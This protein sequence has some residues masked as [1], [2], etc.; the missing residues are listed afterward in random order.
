[1]G[2]EQRDS[3][4][5]RTFRHES[6]RAVATLIRVL[7][8]FDAAEEAVQDAFVVA[9][10]RWPRDGVPSNPGAWITQVAR[11]GAI[12]R[13]RRESTLRE[14]TAILERLEALRPPELGPADRV[15]AGGEIEDDR[16]RL[17]FT[18]C[19]PALSLEAR[20]ALTLRAL[21][22]LSTAEIAR[23]FLV[24]EST[25]AQR[26]VR[27]KRKI[28]QAGI[29][30]EVPDAERMPER[31][32][33]VLATLYLI[34]N[35]GY[36]ASDS[37]SLVR[38]E[39]SAEA[40]RLARVLASTLPR[41]PEVIGLLAL[42]LLTDARRP[43]RVDNS[44]EAV[45]LDEQDRGLWDGERIAEGLAL[46]ERAAAHGPVGPYT[47]Q[48]RIAAAHASAG[49]SGETDWARIV[50]LYEWLARAAP[51]PV[52]ELNRAA[53]VAMRD[54]PQPGLDLIEE[55]DGLDGYRQLH[56]A[57]A[58]LLRRLG[59]DAE[60]RAAYERAIGLTANRVERRY[61]ER[62]VSELTQ[63]R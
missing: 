35:E 27:A 49:S 37:D 30:Y 2:A 60:A 41:E 62:R 52:V 10:E 17:I 33:G 31:L 4:V 1:M 44:G 13:L 14:K 36:L 39:L 29:P 51:S 18:C 26:L 24:A 53:A 21:G 48:A 15:A 55:I 28:A 42:M 5:D 59:R 32:P 3:V 61:L 46:S 38:T 43:A 16:L 22:G 50:R 6:G 58:E 40:I 11:N 12:D 25:M 19:H 47:I 7:G 20:V 56:S 63:A 9:L 8:D 23:A 57:R 54:G 34:F 45:P